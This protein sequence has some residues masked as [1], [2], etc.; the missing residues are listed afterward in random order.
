MVYLIYVN[1]FDKEENKLLELLKIGYTADNKKEI[2]YQTYKL[3]Y[4]LFKVLYEIPDANTLDEKRLQKYFQEFRYSDY[5]LEWFK[6]DK[7][8]VDYFKTHTT[9][10]SLN[11]LGEICLTDRSK[12]WKFR[13]YVE[14]V[15]TRLVNYKISIKELTIEEGLGRVKSITSEVIDDVGIRSKVRLYKYLTETYNISEDIL[16]FG[17]RIE[18][19]EILNFMREFESK[20]IF[21]EKMRL[22]C[23]SNFSDSELSAV[24]ELIPILYKNYYNTLGKSKIGA[25]SYKKHLLDKECN[26]ILNNQGVASSCAERIVSYFCIGKRYLKTEIKQA[27]SVIYKDTG[28]DLTPKASDLE[29]YF[30]LKEVNLVDHSTNKRVKGFEILSKKDEK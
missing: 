2:R 8:I 28:L 14:K 29:K 13:D 27:L 20:T 15:I 5:G 30:E 23:L 19:P 4:P 11:D 16:D 24:L 9:K 17:E 1:H 6:Y 21:S 22:L 25:L 7:S 10:D 26:R 3:H 18:N 12:L